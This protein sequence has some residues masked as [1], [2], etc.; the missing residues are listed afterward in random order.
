[1]FL[2]MKVISTCWRYLIGDKEALHVTLYHREQDVL[3]DA[4]HIRRV[5]FIPKNRWYVSYTHKHALSLQTVQTHNHF[6]CS[7]Q[8]KLDICKS[9]QCCNRVSCLKMRNTHSDADGKRGCVFHRRNAFDCLRMECPPAGRAL[10]WSS[11]DVLDP[12]VTLCGLQMFWK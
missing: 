12:S 9:I 5:F 6:P 7:V 3:E 4:A 11:N 8:S 1:M 10:I 2:V